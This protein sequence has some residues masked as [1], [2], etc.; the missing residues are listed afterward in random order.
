MNT[1]WRLARSLEEHGGHLLVAVQVELLELSSLLHGKEG[2][3]GDATLDASIL[4]LLH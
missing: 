1:H 2:I 4:L 3:E